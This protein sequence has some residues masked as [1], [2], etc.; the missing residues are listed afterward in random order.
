MAALG[1]KKIRV[2]RQCR[3]LLNAI[4]GALNHKAAMVEQKRAQAGKFLPSAG[5]SGAAMEATRNHVTVAGV[6][7][8]D[9]RIHGQNSTMQI[10]DAENHC[11]EERGVIGK[12]GGHERAVS[13][14]N[15]WNEILQAVITH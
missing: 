1:I 8:A 14:T 13:A 4:D 2:S 10:A 12:N 5:S 3:Q 6:L 11:L 7:S 9:R 15:H